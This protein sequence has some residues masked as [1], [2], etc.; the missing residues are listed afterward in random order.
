MLAAEA[1]VRTD[2]PDR[3]LAQLCRHA[4][5]V[6]RL[7]HRPPSPDGR[8]AQ[9]PPKVEHAQSSGS[10]GTVDFGWG[11]CIMQASGNVLTLRAEAD[12]EGNLQLIQDIITRDIER[13]GRRDHLKVSW[14][15][16]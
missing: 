16:L 8:G 15:R 2:R 10:R 6:H 1:R 5:Q 3:Y 12:D 13:F 11:R 9:P 14:Q 7:R 4:Q